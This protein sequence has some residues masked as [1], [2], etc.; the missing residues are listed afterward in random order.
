MSCFLVEPQ[1]CLTHDA[2]PSSG[3]S[4]YWLELDGFLPTLHTTV[5]GPTDYASWVPMPVFVHV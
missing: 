4:L 3:Q 2:A 5:N 1:Q